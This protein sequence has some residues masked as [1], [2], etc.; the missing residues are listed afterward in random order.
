VDTPK[1]D[2]M[3]LQQPKR[4]MIQIVTDFPTVMFY[5]VVW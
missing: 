2:C 3:H 5:E 4:N 1:T